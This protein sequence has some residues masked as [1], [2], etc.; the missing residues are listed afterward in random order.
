MADNES[1]YAL[2]KPVVMAHPNLFVARAFGSKGKETGEPK[3]SANFLFPMDSEDL[4]ALKALAAKVARA[5]WPDR[6]FTE[7]KFPFTNGDKLADKRKKKTGKDDGDFQRGHVM[8]AA[9]SKY[10]PR[11]SFLNGSKI[12]ELDND[13]AIAANKGKFYFGVECLAQFNLVAYD[14]VANNPDG[15]TVYLNQVLST[16]KGKKLSGA[17]SASE[18]FKGYAGQASGED[19]TLPAD[20]DDDIPF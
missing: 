15:I 13:A 7:L 17:A 9:R 18:T 16:G 6:P 5:K 2:T 3:F 20:T 8:V 14:G 1:L 11:L 10:Q 12:V 19:P 4:K